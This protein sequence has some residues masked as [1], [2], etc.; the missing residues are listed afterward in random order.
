[1]LLCTALRAFAVRADELMKAHPPVIART[2]A[3]IQ[4]AYCEARPPSLPESL[5]L[6]FHHFNIP[7]FHLS[8]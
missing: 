1:V 3:F 5:F 7:L 8:S 2:I 6:V 4:K